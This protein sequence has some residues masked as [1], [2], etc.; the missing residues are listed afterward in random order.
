MKSDLRSILEKNEYLPFEQNN[1][2][3]HIELNHI[4]NKEEKSKTI[5]FINE[6]EDKGGVYIYQLVGKVNV[7]YV[8]Q[9]G[10]IKRR[11]KR[12]YRKLYKT[13]ETK[14]FDINDKFFH[15]FLAPLNFRVAE[16]L[17][18]VFLQLLF[19]FFTFFTF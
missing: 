7:L 19:L 16:Y 6:L 5:K 1:K 11:F 14:D 13:K 4:N 12:H 10:S 2:W 17:T 9:T 3:E 8:G 18:G 15:I